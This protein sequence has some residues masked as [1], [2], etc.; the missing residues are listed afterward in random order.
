LY[1]CLF[2][3]GVP[4]GK[5]LAGP[6]TCRCAHTLASYCAC[7]SSPRPAWPAWPAR[8]EEAL[9]AFRPWPQVVIYDA[10]PVQQRQLLG[11]PDEPLTCCSIS[12]D[13]MYVVVGGAEGS[14]YS[15][16]AET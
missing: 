12:M 2:L 10:D 16:D 3:A 8:C 9:R 7:I 1:R 4:C 5:L 13:D 14:I 15:W 11:H 6:S